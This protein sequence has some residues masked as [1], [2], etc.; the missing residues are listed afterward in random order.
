MYYNYYYYLILCCI[1]SND[2]CGGSHHLSQVFPSDLL[3]K[4]E[5]VAHDHGFQV[6]GPIIL[7]EV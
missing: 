6:L 1:V 7:I 4:I 5:S 2:P 3:I